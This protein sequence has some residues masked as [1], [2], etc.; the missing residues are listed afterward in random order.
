MRPRSSRG[1]AGRAL[2]FF[3]PFILGA[4]SSA[5]PFLRL[6][7]G[8]PVEGEL[9]GREEA[10]YEVELAKGQWMHVVAE[11][12][13]IDVV[14]TI[15]DPR[16]SVVVERDALTGAYGIES[17]RVL[18]A[19]NGTYGV[20]LRVL[21]P[22]AIRDRYAIRIVELR[23]GRPEDAR[24]LRAQSAAIE[25][26]R[27]RTAGGSASLARAGVE[28]E[29]AR[30]IWKA[31]GD[32][33]EEALALYELGAIARTRGDNRLALEK[34][35]AGLTVAR[36]AGARQ[37]EA[38]LL[39][40]TGL[41]TLFIGDPAGA[42]EVLGRAIAIAHAAGDVQ[43][44]NEARNTLGWAESLL[45]HYQRAIEIYERAIA[46]ARSRQDRLG[47]AW[48]T[49]GLA[50]A[51]L[52]VGETRRALATYERALELWREV[53]DR[54]GEILALEDLGFL[55]WSSGDFTRGL[56]LFEHALPIA[57]AT[58]DGRSEALALNNMG[59]ARASLGDPSGARQDLL[60]ALKVWRRMHDLPGEIQSLH[61]L[62]RVEAALG[63][64]ETA[65]SLWN[66]ELIRVRA[67]EDPAGEA[68]ALASM[69]R[70]EAGLGRLPAAR[71][72]GEAALAIL[73]RERSGLS[74]RALRSSFLSAHQDAYAVLVD[75]LL[76]LAERE[77]E[78]GE[79]S[80][81]ATGEDS[82]RE[83]FFVSERGR[84]RSFL[85]ALSAS[86]SDRTAPAKAPPPSKAAAIQS[87]LAPDTALIS[88]WLGSDRAVAFV[89][90]RDRFEA[91]RL[92]VSAAD[93]S[94]RVAVY[95][96]LLSRGSRVSEPSGAAA[97]AIGRRLYAD[98]VAPW[99]GR[100]P[101]GVRRLILVPDRAL[102]SLPFEALSRTE[103]PALLED[104]T[105]SYAPSASLFAARKS[106]ATRRLGR[107]VVL[108]LA[109][110]PRGR[111]SAPET[112]T[113]FDGE[114]YELAPLPYAE[115]EA[116]RATEFGGAGSR[117]L[118]GPGAT[119]AE[120][121][122]TGLERFG[123]LHFATHGLLSLRSPDRSALRLSPAPGSSG[124]LEARE[125]YGLRLSS[126]LVVLSA[127]QSGRGRI[128][129]GE[130]V[131]SL[132]RAFLQAGARTVVA[133]LWNVNDARAAE[134]MSY[135]Y[136][137]LA[138]GESK[139]DALRSAKLELIRRHPGLPPRLW[140][141][142]VLI[143]EPDG[144]VPLS[145]PPFWRDWWRG[146]D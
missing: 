18:A 114:R 73:E 80:A 98:A 55:Y 57:R 95:V 119:A 17:L 92:P 44:E 30:A 110:A 43:T 38:R 93:L 126:D 82:A 99:R 125:I 123:V 115:R 146:L 41:A 141:P 127:C 64:S 107:A 121:R 89:A 23:K 76:R 54:R 50:L 128:L 130:G 8:R 120:F 22:N 68:R 4:V 3:L 52:R 102:H 34:Y 2:P 67:V 124:L 135:F 27:L 70:E 51:F 118:S 136:S 100:L 97:A 142:F 53:G 117:M 21:D 133:S 83:A 40:G 9:G 36:A 134:L 104:C 59:L 61:N 74:E 90:A 60:S 39:D 144:G 31:L 113:A 129:P 24:T 71:E 46:V 65:L 7:P 91:I 26:T 48:P 140:A 101:A 72:H 6:E 35:T 79:A 28:M 33:E 69:A 47:E 143:G 56:D 77:R 111:S 88:F 106:S 103:G 62:G 105:I 86:S 96:D 14:V 29:R 112:V 145:A 81:R 108:A 138:R 5:H 15:R 19:S 131:E 12:R 109:E 137:K 85:E 94:E 20:T 16:G 132:A 122:H 87:S 139:A 116:R 66:E 25:G 37:L 42:S 63:R 78:A 75:V 1:F 84:A 49:N 11:Q 32:R 10:R 58:A 13:G 45:G